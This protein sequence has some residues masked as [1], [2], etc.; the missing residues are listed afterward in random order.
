MQKL[1]VNTL[2][3]E[4]MDHHNRKDGFREARKLD[5]YW[6]LRPVACMVNMG[7]EIRI[8]SLSEDNTQSWVRIFHGSNRLV[9]DSNQQHNKF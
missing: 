6:K 1:V 2:F 3:Q 4:V 5:P 7:V 8:W 9:I